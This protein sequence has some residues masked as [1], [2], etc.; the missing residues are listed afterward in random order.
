MLNLTVKS[1]ESPYRRAGW[2]PVALL[3]ILLAMPAG[4]EPPRRESSREEAPPAK[5][6]KPSSE[7]KSSAKAS[8]SSPSSSSRSEPRAR[9]SSGSSSRRSA[10]SERSP[11]TRP[12]PRR[13]SPAASAPARRERSV[14]R[15]RPSR[16]APEIRSQ[17]PRRSDDSRPST[18]ENRRPVNRYEVDPP[19]E[20]DRES[21]P[22]ARPRA[23]KPA[24][25][26]PVDPASADIERR[27][28]RDAG[29]RDRP[30]Q[31]E[32][33]LEAPRDGSA[34]AD[35][36]VTRDRHADTRQRRDYP[37]H[38]HRHHYGCGH[39]GYGPG[40]GAPYSPPRWDPKICISRTTTWDGCPTIN[41]PTTSQGALDL[42]LR[43]KKTE[44]YVDGAYVGVA[45]QFDGF[46]RYLWLDEGTYELAFYKEGYQTIFRQ[47]TIFP[48]VTIAVDDRM[49]PGQAV[50]PTPPA[51]AY[52]PAAEPDPELEGGAE[53]GDMLPPAGFTDDGGRVVVTASPSDAAVYLDGHFVGIAAELAE[54]T[55][56]LMVEPGDHLVDVIRPGYE[57]Q[58]LPLSVAAGERVEL[59]L[60]LQR[61]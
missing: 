21:S 7:S 31:Y 9:S 13:E 8:S 23:R 3:G 37:R 12:Q 58:R 25:R 5:S 49:Q 28:P 51:S 15:D 43:P 39:H 55:A 35:R 32:I 52:S 27:G 30:R 53:S 22:P 14:T 1:H 4:A 60:A 38:R 20:S 54:L 10:T 57:S 42:D 36:P 26:P 50:L 34:R 17:S 46:P 40:H 56:G 29:K 2:W 11:T 47:Y 6:A 24:E 19:G 59:E 18:I 16:P 45:D 61:P 41:N 33:D 48:G 44:I